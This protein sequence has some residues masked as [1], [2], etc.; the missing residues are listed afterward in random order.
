MSDK[1]QEKKGVWKAFTLAE[2]I[3]GGA[4]VFVFAVVIIASLIAKNTAFSNWVATYI[5]DVRA[6]GVSIKNHLP[7]LIRCII[8][9]F[10]VYF[11]SKILRTAFKKHM[12]KNDR[13]KTVVSLLDGIVKY[14]C[15][16]ALFIL[17]LKALGVN[18]GA[19][20]ASVGILTLVIGLGAQSLIA[21]V[22]AGMFIIFENE[23]NVGEIIT[24]DDFRGTVIE[25][26][27]RCTKLQDWAGNI[28]IVNNSDISN[29]VNLSR[30]LSVAVVDCEFPYDVPIEIIE[31][32]LKDNLETM[33]ERIPA[34]VE[35]PFYKGVC[36][37]EDSN[38]AVRLVAKCLED[39]RYQV[40]RDILR[41]YRQ[42]F[43]TKGIDVSYT[44]VVVDHPE[45]FKFNVSKA[46][47]KET[48]DFGKEQKEL[49]RGVEPQEH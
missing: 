45:E 39:D 31:K 26:G 12:E 4:F 22:I 35:G 24:I 14:A 41:E 11:I 33:K 15:A 34:I 40:E 32:L 9:I 37:Y 20:L 6:A 38:V 30:E 28:K 13:K 27:I 1:K 21:D 29:V 25:I 44:H 16:M 23:Y 48:E 2:L 5:W 47:K 10:L 8:Y 3:I 17:I 43:L 36:A 46:L 19:L 18:T 49:S 42:V 7:V